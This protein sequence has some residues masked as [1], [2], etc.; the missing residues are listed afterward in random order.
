MANGIAAPANYWY[1]KNSGISETIGRPALQR[2]MQGMET[3]TLKKGEMLFPTE[4]GVCFL[5]AG[6]IGVSR[7]DASS[8]KEFIL[9]IVKPGEFFGNASLHRNGSGNGKGSGEWNGSRETSVAKALQRSRIGYVDRSGFDNLLLDDVFR[10]EMERSL[11]SRLVQLESRIEELVFNKVRGRLA[12]LL[13]RLSVDFS[14]RC[15]EG[16]GRS[17]N[18]SLTQNDIASLIA[19]SRE[20]TSLTLNEMRRAGIVKFHDR[21][22]CIHDEETLKKLSLAT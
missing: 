15:P 6:C 22:I 5:L 20:I 18:V 11:E 2:L 7:I 19:A 17:I 12:N 8:G 16:T 21:R 10:E 13:L 14:G 4:I 3:R 9:Y 1:L